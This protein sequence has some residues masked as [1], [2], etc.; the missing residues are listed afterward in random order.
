[1]LPYEP[2]RQRIWPV[3]GVLAGFGGFAGAP[4]LAPVPD[5]G[6]QVC[7]CAWSGGGGGVASPVVQELAEV[8][9]GG[10]ELDLGVGGVAA[11]V[12]E[13]A[14]EPGE[15]LGE[16]GLDEGGAAPAE[17]LAGRGGQPGG[18]L[19]PAGGQGAGGAGA[20]GLDGLAADRDQEHQVVQL[21]EAGGGG[22]AVIGQPG[23]DP[24]GQ[25]GQ[26]AVGD[27]GR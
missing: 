3:R 25:A 6:L 22:V 27:G 19:L 24:P 1:M 12:V 23:A 15:E 7:G 10:Q 20:A 26:L 8:V 16:G 4:E 9:D 18:H 14:A 13:V 21:G 17:A 11:A 5:G 2:G